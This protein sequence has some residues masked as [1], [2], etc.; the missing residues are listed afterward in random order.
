MFVRVDAGGH[1]YP[2]H[3]D[4]PSPTPEMLDDPQFNA[5]WDVIQTWDINVPHIYE[6]YVGASGNHVRAIL[7]AL[8]RL[9]DTG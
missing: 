2:W 4:W 8:R 3:P 7:D 9:E 6:G 5:I 1:R